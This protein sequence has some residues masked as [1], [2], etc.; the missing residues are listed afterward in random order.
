MTGLLVLLLGALGLYGVYVAA[1]VARL[2]RAPSAWGDGGSDLPAWAVV[3]AGAGVMLAGWGLPE[4]LALV[5][6]YGLQASHVALGLIPAALA[7]VLVQKRLWIVARVTGLASPGHAV[8]TY[9]R[10][11]TL[12]LAVPVLALLFGLPFA[13]QAL[14]TYGAIVAEATGDAIAAPA[15]IWATAFLLFLTSVIGGWRA[16][17]FVVALQS[18]LVALL[19]VTTAGLGE[20]LLPGPGFLQGGIP[21]ADGLLGGRLPG[22]IQI[23]AGIGKEAPQGGFLTAV[24]VASQALALV[25]LAISPAM[26]LLGMTARAG[27]TFAFGSVWLV[28][29]LASGLLL[30][31]APMLAARGEGLFDGLASIEPLAACGLAL[32]LLAA[33]QVTVGF[34]TTAA[35]LIVSRE[36]VVPFLL[37]GLDDRGA[38]LVGRITMTVTFTLVAAMAAFASTGSAILGSVAL[39]LSAQLLP[40][41]LGICFLRWISRGAVLS[42]LILGSLLV[43]FTE[44]PGLVLWEAAFPPLPWGRWPLTAHSAAWGLA[45]NFAAVLLVAIFT[46]K[47]EGRLDRDRLHDEFL[48]RHRNRLGRVGQA[49]WSLTFLWA[50]FALGPGAILGNTFFSQPVFTAGEAALG[51]PSLWIWQLLFWLIGVPLVWWMAYAGRLGITSVESL[52]SVDIGAAPER[53]APLWIERGLQRLTGR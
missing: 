20:A 30:L 36:I 25:G 38:R 19:M 52:R 18:M 43:L 9:Y 37:P 27:R 39:P 40:A 31:L 1:R 22:V 23:S 4:H 44:P 46:R 32:M 8:G 6:T 53:R 51:V 49:K 33:C 29:G 21:V 35:A 26:L 16:T 47:G 11:V 17:V 14:S 48:A 10:S 12:R 42:G 13:A 5:R 45:F 7:L 2:G 50:F 34:F 3:F 28:A 24:A 41:L 15:A